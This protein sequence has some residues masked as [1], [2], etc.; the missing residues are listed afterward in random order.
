[1]FNGGYN[2]PFIAH[3]R[4]KTGIHHHLKQGW[5]I[6]SSGQ[7]NPFESYAVVFRGWMNGD[8]GLFAGVDSYAFTGDFPGQGLLW[9]VIG[10]CYYKSG[11]MVLP[12]LLLCVQRYFFI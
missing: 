10:H 2:G 1:M 12:G 5:N 3:H 9:V 6:R 7:I 4:G 11:Y 8:G